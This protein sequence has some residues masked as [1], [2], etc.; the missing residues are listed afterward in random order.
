[1]TTGSVNSSIFTDSDDK[2]D[3]VA[4][5][6]GSQAESL[7]HSLT[8]PRQ[9]QRTRRDAKWDPIKGFPCTA[10]G[11]RSLQWRLRLLKARQVPAV[12]VSSGNRAYDDALLERDPSVD[13]ASFLLPRVIHR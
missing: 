9:S 4:I 10:G 8:L 13:R 1:M 5:A 2:K 11:F 3:R 6:E 12:I 7:G